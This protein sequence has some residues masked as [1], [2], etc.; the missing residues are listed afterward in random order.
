MAGVGIGASTGVIPAQSRL[1]SCRSGKARHNC[2]YIQTSGGKCPSGGK[3]SIKSSGSVLMSIPRRSGSSDSASNQIT[4]LASST[5]RWLYCCKHRSH[6]RVI[7]VSV[8]ADTFRYVPPCLIIILPLTGV[9]VSNSGISRSTI[10]SRVRSC[11]FA[12]WGIKSGSIDRQ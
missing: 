9:S 4:S 2:S 1:Q 8:C 7:I 11:R 12:S 3:E 10:T 6:L 5:S